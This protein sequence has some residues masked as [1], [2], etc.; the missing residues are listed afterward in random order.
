MRGYFLVDLAALQQ[1]EEVIGIAPQHPVEGRER[2][3]VVPQDVL[4]GGLGRGDIED[5]GLALVGPPAEGET[6]LVGIEALLE[7]VRLE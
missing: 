1:A 3:V 4:E 5:D 2:R 7:A 6:V